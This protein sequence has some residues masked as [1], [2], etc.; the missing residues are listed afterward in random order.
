MT[1]DQ[2]AAHVARI[3]KIEDISVDSH[4]SGGRAYRRQRRVKI[5]PVKSDIT[6]AVAM[7]ELGHILSSGQRG[8]RLDKEADAW[9]WA[10][11]HALE[12]TPAMQAKMRDCLKSYLDKAARSPRMKAANAEH[13]IHKLME[14]SHD[15]SNRIS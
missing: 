13:P 3:C 6:Y 5:R 14:S 8:T 7:H 9:M 4:S 10:K 12:W 1:A 15:V 2:Y 11:A